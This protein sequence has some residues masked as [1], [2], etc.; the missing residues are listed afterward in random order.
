MTITLGV[1][2]DVGGIQFNH[3]LYECSHL[4]QVLGYLYGLP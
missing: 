1:A 2:I 4:L 3:T